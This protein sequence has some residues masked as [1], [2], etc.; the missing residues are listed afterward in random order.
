MIHEGLSGYD[1][2]QRQA[3]STENEKD[4]GNGDGVL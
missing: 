1:T 4:R 3:D 2:G